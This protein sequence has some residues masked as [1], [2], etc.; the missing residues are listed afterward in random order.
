MVASLVE[1]RRAALGLTQTEVAERATAALREMGYPGKFR[2]NYISDLEQG[3]TALPRRHNRAAL[4]KVLR[5]SEL[6]WLSAAGE[7]DTVAL[8]EHPD[9]FDEY[10]GEFVG[11]L[12]TQPRMRDELEEVR[13]SRGEKVYRDYL[14][15]LW[16][17]WEANFRATMA[18]LRLGEG[19]D[20]T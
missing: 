11:W 12:R 6:E 2:Q 10:E 5:I 8:N 20:V 16:S 3:K 14:R 1:S 19:G 17:A 15:A 13:Q 9:G 18:A 7:A 4:G